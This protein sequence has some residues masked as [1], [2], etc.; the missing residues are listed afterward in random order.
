MNNAEKIKDLL[1]NGTKISQALKEVCSSQKI[2]IPFNDGD[3]NI[4]LEE[5]GLSVRS[6]NALKRAKLNTLNDV[7][8]NFDKSGWNSIKNLGKVSATE[9]FEKI[10]DVAWNSMDDAQ[11]EEFLNSV[12]DDV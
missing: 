2:Y 8:Q 12:E 4:L 1:K 6:Y 11:K 3:F 7:I 9:I 10:I 5:L